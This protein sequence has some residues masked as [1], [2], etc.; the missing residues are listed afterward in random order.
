VLFV[1]T[2]LQIKLVINQGTNEILVT[3]I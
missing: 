1:I 2:V 3:D